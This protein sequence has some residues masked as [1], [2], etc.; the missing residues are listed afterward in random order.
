QHARRN[1]KHRKA[2]ANGED[3][4]PQEGIP[5]LLHGCST[6]ADGFLLR[7]SGILA[8]GVLDLHAFGLGLLLAE[9]LR[10]WLTAAAH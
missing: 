6:H 9:L 10:Q 1:E 8:L 2:T 4:E 5:T 7:L 3:C